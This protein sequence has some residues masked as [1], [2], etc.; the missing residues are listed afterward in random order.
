MLGSIYE[1]YDERDKY[2]AIDG[3]EFPP[4]ALV[5]GYIDDNAFACTLGVS[6]FPQPQIEMYYGDKAA[7]HE[8]VEV[9][10]AVKRGTFD[11]EVCNKLLNY[12]SALAKLPWYEL[13]WIGH[14]HTVDCEV[15]DGFS[16]VMLIDSSIMT[17][18]PSPNFS[19]FMGDRVNVLWLVPLTNEEFERLS[20]FENGSIDMLKRYDGN[21][22][23]LV[24][25]DGKPKFIK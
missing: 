14:G 22:K 17:E 4:K 15:I 23:E 16:Q 8:R 10:M 20:G 1:F 19:D 21:I 2:Y 18:I 11:N 6:L 7:E 25:F 9:A 12:I 3:G 24:I 13:S 5:T